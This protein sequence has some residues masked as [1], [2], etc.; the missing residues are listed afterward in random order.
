MSA[1]E[2]EKRL[3][4][5]RSGKH[6]TAPNDPIGEAQFRWNLHGRSRIVQSPNE[7]RRTSAHTSYSQLNYYTFRIGRAS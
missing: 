7:I 3:L 4:L 6:A 1:L 5:V 2:W